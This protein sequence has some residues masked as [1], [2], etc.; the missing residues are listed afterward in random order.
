MFDNRSDTNKATAKALEAPGR[1]KAQ[2][3]LQERCHTMPF[4]TNIRILSAISSPDM[5][6]GLT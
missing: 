2:Q 5:H 6:G 4:Q 3:H 1:S